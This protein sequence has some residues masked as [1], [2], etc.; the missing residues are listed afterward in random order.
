MG[1]ETKA[2]PATR[3]QINCDFVR[4]LGKHTLNAGVRRMPRVRFLANNSTPTFDARTVLVA[5]SHLCQGWNG[6]R[7]ARKTNVALQHRGHSAC[8]LECDA[9]AT[10]ADVVNFT[11]NLIFFTGGS[12]IREFL[13]RGLAMNSIS[14]VLACLAGSRRV[15]YAQLC[16]RCNRWSITQTK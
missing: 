12:N 13:R 2:A 8:P 6:N 16:P 5:P 9:E 10:P 3:Y 1:R 7:Y 11:L 14:R 15:H 4:N